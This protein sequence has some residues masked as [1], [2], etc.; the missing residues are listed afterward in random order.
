M[1]NS[2]NILPWLGGVILGILLI[3]VISRIFPPETTSP[4]IR[5]E[6]E[7]VNP[8]TQTVDLNVTVWGDYYALLFDTT[9]HDVPVSLLDSM[10]GAEEVKAE[11]LIEFYDTYK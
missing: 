3:G 9:I 6:I 11:E 1:K 7:N 10:K 5:I 8:L 4:R 2:E